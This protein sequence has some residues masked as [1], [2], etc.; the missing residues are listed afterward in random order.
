MTVLA[1]A[2]VGLIVALGSAPANA[3]VTGD[4]D[5]DP[6][7]AAMLEEVPGGILI[8]STHAVWPEL[9][10]ALSVRPDSGF[11]ARSVGSCATD[12]ICAYSG[13]SLSGSVLTFG[14]CG[15]LSVPGSFSVKS[16]ANARTSGYAQPRNGTT[17]LATIYAGGWSN[18]SGTTTNIRCVL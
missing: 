2:V 3:A 17:V 6:Q 14:T 12:K 8:D 13:V 11:A 18:V 9:D 7:V 15:I 4:R 10:M 1:A 16:A 5:V